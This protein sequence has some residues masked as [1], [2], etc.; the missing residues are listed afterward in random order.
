M[1]KS[2]KREK[3][4]VELLRQEGSSKNQGVKRRAFSGQCFRIV[5]YLIV[6]F[7]PQI[8]LAA[9]TLSAVVN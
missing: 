9:L 5:T 6:I 4:A 3:I 8:C 2:G 7:T 1:R